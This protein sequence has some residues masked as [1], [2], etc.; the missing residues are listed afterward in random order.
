MTLYQLA[1]R[2]IKRSF[3]NFYIFLRQKPLDERIE[4]SIIK[5]QQTCF[6]ITRKLLKQNDTEIIFAPIS[7]KKII[8]NDRLNVV[9][10]L[11]HQKVFVTN[12]LCHYSTLMGARTWERINYMFNN[13]LEQSKKSHEDKIN[14]QINCSL[15][16]IFMKI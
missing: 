14:S 7:G 10:T 6:H 3:L 8:I 2:K 15:T 12:H 11:H 9:V 16:D 1:K 5:H 13:N 4:P